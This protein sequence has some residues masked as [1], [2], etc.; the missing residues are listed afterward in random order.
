MIITPI[1]GIAAAVDRFIKHAKKN[2]QA[3][4]HS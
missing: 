4:G 1:A 2:G 3:E